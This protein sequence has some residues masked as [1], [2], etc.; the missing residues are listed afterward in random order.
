[1]NRSRIDLHNILVNI[2]G[3]NYVY[4]QPPETIQLKYPCIIYSLSRFD[5]KFADDKRY[6]DLKCYDITLIDK[7]PESVF[8]DPIRNIKYCELTRSYTSDNLNHFHFIL[9]F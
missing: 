5:T 8:V 6:R 1:M 3:S 2:L 9:Y 4:Y 7:D